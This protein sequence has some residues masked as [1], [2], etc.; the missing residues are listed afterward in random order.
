MFIVVVNS[1]F[2]NTS[3][4]E[5]HVIKSLPKC[6][7]KG[8]R[9]AKAIRITLIVQTIVPQLIELGITDNLH[10]IV[11]TYYLK[12]C[13]LFLTQN[14]VE[15]VSDQE[16]PLDWA[17][18]IY[19]KLREFLTKGKMSAFFDDLEVKF[20]CKH[21]LEEMQERRYRCCRERAAMLLI[22]DRIRDVLTRY[23]AANTS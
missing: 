19:D 4:I 18:C 14:H 7:I 3:E 22:T 23:R 8:Y 2:L 15:N 1:N 12:T 21:S 10:N 16:S 5:N 11:K 9:I 6:I 20:E 17:I 13:V